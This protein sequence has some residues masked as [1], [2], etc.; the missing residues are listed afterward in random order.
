MHSLSLSLKWYTR[1]D[2]TSQNRKVSVNENFSKESLIHLLCL[3]KRFSCC[4]VEM[5]MW[6]SECLNGL[7]EK[8]HCIY[9]RKIPYKTQFK[10]NTHT[11]QR[12]MRMRSEWF[13]LAFENVLN[14]VSSVHILCQNYTCICGWHYLHLAIWQYQKQWLK[15]CWKTF[16]YIRSTFTIMHPL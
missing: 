7:S 9:P 11:I 6:M 16:F 1:T 4:F 10:K 12:E 2:K 5:W 15:D 3:C 8:S 13:S 14:K